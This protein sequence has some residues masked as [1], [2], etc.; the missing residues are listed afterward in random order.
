MNQGSQVAHSAC[1]VVVLRMC[2]CCPTV[3]C[4]ARLRSSSCVPMLT[5]CDPDQVVDLAMALRSE[6][7]L[8]G[9]GD[10]EQQLRSRLQADG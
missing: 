10:L 2:W 6:A 7:L 3:C 4:L 5:L 9:I 1:F 8:P